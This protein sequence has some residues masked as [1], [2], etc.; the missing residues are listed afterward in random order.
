MNKN[1]ILNALTDL[2]RC[3]VLVPMAPCGS[4][5]SMPIGSL[6]SFNI[7]AES[8]VKQFDNS[9]LKLSELEDGKWYWNE[10]YGWCLMNFYVDEFDNVFR[11]IEIVNGK[12]LNLYD[13]FKDGDFYKKNNKQ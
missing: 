11:K 9:P 6:K 4:T 1:E 10:T 13:E 2:S 7:I 5:V 3:S 12:K 8:I